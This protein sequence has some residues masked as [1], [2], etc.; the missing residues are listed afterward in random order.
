MPDSMP[1]KLQLLNTCDRPPHSGLPRERERERER[2]KT[3]KF[4]DYNC[5]MDH[6]YNIIVTMLFT[7]KG[8]IERERVSNY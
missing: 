2:V 1:L 3:S 4:C 7:I 5:H 6:G 8:E